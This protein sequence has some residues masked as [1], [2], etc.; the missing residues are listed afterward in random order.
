MRFF[1]RFKNYHEE[2]FRSS[3]YRVICIAKTRSCFG[4]HA[5]YF[6]TRKT[7]SEMSHPRNMSWKRRLSGWVKKR[8]RAF[9]FSI[10]ILKRE[11]W[12]VR[13][14][15]RR[16][17]GFDYVIESAPEMYK[18]PLSFGK[19]V[20]E[21]KVSA[22]LPVRPRWNPTKHSAT[23]MNSAI[24]SNGSSSA[25]T[26]SMWVFFGEFSI[27]FRW[28]RVCPVWDVQQALSSSFSP[29]TASRG[30]KWSRGWDGENF[31]RCVVFV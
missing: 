2:F 14:S 9:F 4:R 17:R 29:R 15:F 28:R 22:L 3:V 23:I 12:K 8:S 21:T 18:T 20:E 5:S 30:D 24:R 25:R 6:S 10:F 26:P 16:R 1:H 11:I 13:R 31:I 19:C 27:T 7:N